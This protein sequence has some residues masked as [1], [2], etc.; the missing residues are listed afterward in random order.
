M[1]GER[2]RSEVAPYSRSGM[3]SPRRRITSRPVWNYK[4]TLPSEA[5]IYK[6]NSVTKI[7]DCRY[8]SSR[9][10]RCL[11]STVPLSAAGRWRAPVRRSL[12]QRRLHRNKY[13]LVG[14]AAPTKMWLTISWCRAAILSS[15]PTVLLGGWIRTEDAGPV[16][17]AATRIINAYQ[18]WY[19][20]HPKRE[21]STF[22]DF[23]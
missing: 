2:G 4:K 13:R 10:P 19:I 5:T 9:Y 15:L 1:C 21:I 18:A 14:R 16:V 8:R 7:Y 23:T 22:Q 17:E 3:G 12:S 20:T 6:D 11:L